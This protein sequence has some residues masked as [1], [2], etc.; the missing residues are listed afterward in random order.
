MIF[1]N[2]TARAEAQRRRML[3]DVKEAAIDLEHKEI[4]ALCLE[5]E[6]WGRS[7]YL[8]RHPRWSE[9]RD[10]WEELHD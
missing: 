1:E 5:L 8:G 3:R 6:Q 2:P 7:R 10:I 9:L 4:L